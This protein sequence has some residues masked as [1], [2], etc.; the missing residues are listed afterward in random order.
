MA[1]REL[2]NVQTLA[3]VLDS[4]LVDPLLGLLLPGAGDLAG[5]L[6]GL[7]AVALAI[8]RRMS[9]VVIARML[10]NLSIDALLGAIPLLGDLFD[11]AFHANERNVRLLVE[12]GESG[13]RATPRDWLMV[14]GAAVVFVG[15][16]A[17]AAYI[18]VALLRLLA[19]AVSAV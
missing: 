11:F 7:Y 3:R 12:R 13:G 16:M 15:S 17:L 9:P 5:A 1:D 14:V 6:L 8:R 4:Y 2:R 18:L 10:L 19:R